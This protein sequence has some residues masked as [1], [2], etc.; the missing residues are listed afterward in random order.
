MFLKVQ[1]YS[2]KIVKLIANVDFLFKISLL[3]WFMIPIG[4]LLVPMC[5]AKRPTAHPK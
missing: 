1:L 2:R 4:L 3:E 5:D